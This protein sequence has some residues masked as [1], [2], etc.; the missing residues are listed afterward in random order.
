M[1]KR[2]KTKRPTTDDRTLNWKRK[3]S[4]ELLTSLKT[5]MTLGAPEGKTITDP[6][7][8]PNGK[9]IETGNTVY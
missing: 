3:I 6:L 9:S 5:Q 4:L 8:V 2:K 1:A 7:L